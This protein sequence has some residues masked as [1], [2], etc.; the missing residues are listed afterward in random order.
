L[1]GFF[2]GCLSS[3]IGQYIAAKA[4]DRCLFAMRL[5]QDP[6]LHVGMHQESPLVTL[7]LFLFLLRRPLQPVVFGNKV[8]LHAVS[9]EKIAVD[10]EASVEKYMQKEKLKL[11][12]LPLLQRLTKLFRMSFFNPLITNVKVE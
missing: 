11:H 10:L 7:L 2:I 6:S 5:R 12:R 9:F 1:L 3:V 8:I 4:I